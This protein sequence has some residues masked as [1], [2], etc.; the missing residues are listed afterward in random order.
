MSRFF[1]ATRQI[2]Y[3]VRD[4]ERAMRFWSG[5]LGVGPFYVLREIELRNFHYRG[6]PAR[7]PVIT[8]AFA[9]SGDVQLELIQQHNDAPSAYREFLSAGREGMQHVSS[10]F[11]EPAEYDRA[12]TALLDQGLQI[13]QES[14]GDD[15]GS[16]RFAYFETGTPEGHLIEVSETLLPDIREVA[17]MAAAEAVNW[18]GSNPIRDVDRG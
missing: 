4:I 10:W 3:V 18:D 13:V 8:V 14:L 6:R 2:G 1:G 5:T 15:D 7:A 16:A 11:S 17:E 12:R 9:N